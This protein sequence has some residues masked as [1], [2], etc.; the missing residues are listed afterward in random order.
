MEHKTK[1]KRFKW[2]AIILYIVVLCLLT[3]GT[4]SWFIFDKTATIEN[5]GDMQIVAGSRLDISLDGGATWGSNFP[6]D[7]DSASYPDI[8]GDGKNFICP[9]FLDSDDNAF[10][11]D[12]NT[13]RIIDE[14]NEDL[15]YITLRITFRTAANTEVY[16]SNESYVSPK[17]L[18][19]SDLN[20]SIYGN[21]SRD[22]IAGAVRVAF[23]EEILDQNGVP[24]EEVRNI[25]IPNDKYELYYEA[26]LAK[27]KESGTREASYGYQYLKDGKIETY[28]FSH[29]DYYSKKVTVGGS[30][31]LASATKDDGSTAMINQSQK[32]LDF[33]SEVEDGTTGVREKTLIVRIWVEGTDR[34]AEKALVG[35][36]MDYKLHFICIDK[37]ENPNSDKLDKIELS[38]SDKSLYIPDSDDS[39]SGQ[40]QYSINGIDWMDY[41]SNVV[42]D[43]EEKYL[44]VR[45][46]ETVANKASDVRVIEINPKNDT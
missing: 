18:D 1:S 45:F 8:T 37:D 42:Y 27:F 44:Y 39:L 5:K 23:S 46:I 40:V 34:E 17:S 41:G 26:D 30:E 21:I 4:L 3:T 9:M 32:L 20:K 31:F 25:W 36:E 43:T 22:G 6:V 2:L 14:K 29:E 11:D 33:S 38:T 35:G 13:F 12:P 15:Y 28:T 19:V 10:L 16:L 7:I 24:M